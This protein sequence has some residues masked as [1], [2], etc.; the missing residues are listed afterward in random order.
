MPRLGLLPLDRLEPRPTLTDVADLGTKPLPL[1]VV[2]W[3]RHFMGT[4][5]TGKAL[6]RNPLLTAPL[7]DAVEVVMLDTLHTVHLGV[8]LRYVS[9]ICWRTIEGNPWGIASAP[10]E[11]SVRHLKVDMFAYYD[12]SGVPVDKRVGDLT[13][14]IMGKM[15][16]S[17]IKLKSAEAT[18]LLPFA[19]ELCRRYGGS[20]RSADVLRA[21]GTTLQA[22]LQLLVD[23]PAQVPLG[24]CQDLLDMCLR[25]LRLLSQAGVSFFTEAPPLVPPHGPHPFLWQPARLQYIPG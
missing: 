21:A 14:G 11:T 6:H 23:A 1:P 7:L 2:F 19:V 16:S 13:I 18:S 4:Q 10:L 24:M 9:E 3:R 25:R 8:I 15:D 12:V 17:S 22:Y 20:I 5:V